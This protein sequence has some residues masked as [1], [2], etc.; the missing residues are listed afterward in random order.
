MYK[1]QFVP[2]VGWQGRLEPY[3]PLQLDPSAQVLFAVSEQLLLD[4]HVVM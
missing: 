4:L 1:A 2:G 3:A